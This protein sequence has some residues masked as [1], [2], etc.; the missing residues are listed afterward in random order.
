MRYDFLP[1][2]ASAAL[3]ACSARSSGVCFFIRARTAFLALAALE[4]AF[5]VVLM[6]PRATAAG[7]FFAM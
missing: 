5:L 1:H 7:F 2:R 6:R 3:R 4:A